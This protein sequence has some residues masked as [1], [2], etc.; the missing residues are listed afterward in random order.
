MKRTYLLILIA[1]VTMLSG[2]S[3]ASM[4]N[5]D[6][7]KLNN[8]AREYMDKEDYPEAIMRLRAIN[9]LNPNFPQTYYNLGVAYQKNQD[10]DYY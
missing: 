10:W 7:Q 3:Q 6:I 4:S 2:C 9:D 8:V 1:C 5:L